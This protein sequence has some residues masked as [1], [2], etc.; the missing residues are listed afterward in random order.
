MSTDPDGIV[1]RARITPN[2]SLD[3]RGQ[4]ILFACVILVTTALCIPFYL[5]GALPVVGFFGLDVALL[6]IAFRVSN[7]RARAYEELVLTRIE[8]LFRRVTW[9]GRRSEWRFNPLWVRLSSE[10]HAEFGMQRLALV[11]GRRSVEMAT[12]LGA[13]EKADFALALKQALAAARRG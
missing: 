8:L 10:D 6:W 3:R 13:E 9:R 11:E 1:F 12:F 7:Q 5:L 4:I 2:R